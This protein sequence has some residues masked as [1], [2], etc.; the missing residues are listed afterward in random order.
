VI[1]N[2][3]IPEGNNIVFANVF[4]QPVTDGHW[5]CVIKRDNYVVLVDPYG[6]DNK[7]TFIVPFLSPKHVYSIVRGQRFNEPY[8]GEYCV[9]FYKLFRQ[10]NSW[11]RAVQLLFPE[12]GVN[13]NN[14][15]NLLN[16]FKV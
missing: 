3:H 1:V 8:C 6:F 2:N 10:V 13:R 15:P 5:V 14:Y 4:H 7:Q 9:A 11:E 16:I 12:V